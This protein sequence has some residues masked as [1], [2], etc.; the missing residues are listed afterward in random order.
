L[1]LKDEQEKIEKEMNSLGI[2]R[3]YRNIRSARKSGGESTTLYGI[4][5]MKEALDSVSDGIKEFLDEALSGGVG[6]Y[7]NSA[8]T[9]GLMNTEVCAYL[10]LKYS[11]DGVSQRSPFTRVAM[12]LGSAIEDQFKFDIWDKGEESRKIFRRIKK[13]I[14]SRTSNRLYRRYNIIRTM[15]RTEVVEHDAWSKTE[16][17]HLGSKLIDVLI[18]TT[19]LMEIK[20]VQFGRKKRVI[21]LQAN[22]ATLYWIENVNK[23]GEGLHPYF[24]PC[25]VPPIDWSS[26][27]NGGYHTQRIDPIPM[28]KTRNREYLEEM[29]NHSMPME[30]GAINA[31]QRTKWAVN[32]PI[33]EVMKK[34]WE[35]GDSWANLPPREDYKVLPCPIQGK[36]KDMTPEQLDIFIKWKKKAM[37][38]HDLNA[39]M[40]SKRIQLVRTI[41][42]ARKFRQY[43]A[44]YFV[45]QCDFRGRKYTV[46]SFLTPQGPDYAKSLLHFSEEFPINTEEQRDYFAVHGANSFGYD[47]VS[48]KDRVAWAVEN[49]D[50]IS[51]SA[52]EPLNFRWWTKADE[53]WTFLAWCMEWSRF[54]DEGFGFMSRLPIC[55][56]G[57]NNGLQHFSAMLRDT[58]G[59]KATNLTPEAVPQDI[60]QLVADV[61]HKKV[62]EDANQ[63]LPYSKEWLSFGI[64]RKITKRPVMVVPYGGTRFSCRAYVEDAM[65]DRILQNPTFNP[66]GEHVYEA[67]LYLGKHVWDAI[68]EVVIKA[69]EAMSWL[70]DIGRKMSEKNLPV[71]WETPSN[72]VVQQIYKSMRPR[73]ITTHIDNV[74]IKPSVLEETE[75]ID[76]RRSINGVSP[77][78]VHSMDA[79]A[80][81][82][83]INRCIK[84]GIKDFSVVHDSYG[85]HAHFVPRMADAIR[86]SFVEMYSETDVLTNFYEEIVDVIPE[87]EEPPNRGDLD[88]MGVLDSEY[89]FS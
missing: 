59:G 18:R 43:K 56:D 35:T 68:G 57:S 77:N 62:T 4:T 20:T 60:Y 61:V 54:V 6:K 49:T 12:K 34:C 13:K 15:S 2:D 53:P 80:L 33:L 66:F 29:K 28:I 24:Y 64:D 27:F 69:R 65:N 38:V 37:T 46:N 70:Q 82:L 48:F 5:L 44:I 55:L 30:Y 31:L 23:E 22:K 72:F 26:P 84:E 39:K 75:N 14:A 10:T 71:I 50:N 32:E 67:S 42:M 58:I 16:R 79:T 85:V 21:Y 40:T 25:V 76:R 78:F 63:R 88:I 73:R 81:T 11:L 41:A 51:K 87:L 7:Q 36:K 52:R 89:F 83:T 47:K 9:L 74:L 8:L 45:Y 1:N 17:L 3:Y 19:G 86:T